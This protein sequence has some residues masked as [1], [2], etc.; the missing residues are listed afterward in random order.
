MTARKAPAPRKKE[1]VVCRIAYPSDCPHL[2]HYDNC[3]PALRRLVR[4]AGEAP[5]DYFCSLAEHRRN[6]RRT[7]PPPCNCWKRAVAR[8]RREREKG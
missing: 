1:C 3:T 6:E 4:A 8:F 7:V 2:A 5:H